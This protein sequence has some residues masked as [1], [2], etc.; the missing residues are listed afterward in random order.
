MA[1]TW[2]QVVE[3]ASELST[4]PTATQNALLAIVDRQIDD[5]VWSDLA[6]DGR[7]YLAAHLATLYASGGSAAGP[8][9]SETL[10]PMARSYGQ[11]AGVEGPLTSTK[12]GQFYVYLLSLLPTSLGFVP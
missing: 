4:V 5:D 7:V 6:N 11:T 2:S 9:T 3:I 10:G 12:Y 1:V 8:I